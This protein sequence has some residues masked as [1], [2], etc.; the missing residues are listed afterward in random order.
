MGKRTKSK[1][2]SD[3]IG[4]WF[5]SFRED[6]LVQH[7]GQ[8]VGIHDENTIIVEL[9]SW[10]DGYPTHQILE[11]M[12]EAKKWHLY[13]SCE[14]MNHEYERIHAHRMLAE[15][16]GESKDQEHKPTIKDLKSCEASE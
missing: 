1:S 6:G 8:I 7:Q 10:M 15:I 13:N 12:E 11:T 4:R 14:H 9:C 2:K 3:L 16:R 5:H